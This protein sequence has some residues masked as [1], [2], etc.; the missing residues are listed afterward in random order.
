MSA[1]P[2]ERA[3]SLPL[4]H[5]PVVEVGFSLPGA[6]ACRTTGGRGGTGD[7]VDHCGLCGGVAPDVTIGCD[8]CR[9]KYHPVTQCTGLKKPT[10]DAVL[11]DGDAVKFICSACR[12]SG[13]A[14]TRVTTR[15][16]SANLSPPDVSLPV[17]ISQVF[18]IV[19]ALAVSMTSLTQQ[20]TA[21]AATVANTK[22]APAPTMPPPD[23]SAIQGT[24]SAQQG[25]PINRGAL[26]AEMREFEERQRRRESVI[27]RGLEA[28]TNE[29][30]GH[31][32]GNITT[33]LIGRRVPAESL[34]CI[35]R[36]KCLY[37]LKVNDKDTRTDLLKRAPGLK[38]NPNYKNVYISRDLTYDQ[39]GKLRQQRVARRAG[40]GRGGGARTTTPVPPS[41]AASS[42]TE[43]PDGQPGAQASGPRDT[44]ESGRESPDTSSTADPPGQGFR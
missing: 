16:Q 24:P 27:V 35:D 19:K 41:P 5:D 1:P 26:F 29:E 12:C 44:G 30:V 36:S 40:R 15:S 10:I 13:P 11:A 20:V 42:A 31:M 17:S 38:D 32:F 14:P 2:E 43:S 22:A 4:L 37:R 25:A 23:R 33:M 39:R 3:P 21:L 34:Y 9:L 18:E 8:R 28:N 7:R 6:P